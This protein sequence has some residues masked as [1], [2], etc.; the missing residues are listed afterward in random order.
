ME[1][2]Y[3]YN[4]K[5]VGSPH[6][7][8]PTTKEQGEYCG[9]GIYMVPN[10]VQFDDENLY[11]SLQISTPTPSQTQLSSEQ[12]A[13]QNTRPSANAGNNGEGDKK[14]RGYVV[15]CMVLTVLAVI[16]IVA[17]VIGA[18][19]LRGSSNAQLAICALEKESL[20]YTS[21]LLDEIQ[22]L[23]SLLVDTQRNISQLSSQLS[24]Q[25]QEV[26]SVSRS[27]TSI[28]W[29]SSSVS[30]LST[31]ALTL[32]TSVSSVS[33]SAYWNYYFASISISQLSYSSRYYISPSVSQLST[34]VSQL[35]SSVSR[36]SYSSHYYISPSVSQLSTS[37]S[38]LSSSVSRL[39][40]SSRYYISPSVSR[41]STSVSQLSSSF[42]NQCTRYC[43]G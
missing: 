40:Y 33:S 42:A 27:L 18:L 1:E 2:R 43:Y 14:K 25:Q 30:R 16:A 28:S 24:N 17:V 35:S 12:H 10:E 21:Y 8:E 9:T 22:A 7:Q 19:S 26:T 3:Q 4:L 36:L 29:L 38:R 34:S 5:L 11:E 13:S 37:V 32:S 6:N 20:N 23:N 41:L 39:S 31:S 15:V